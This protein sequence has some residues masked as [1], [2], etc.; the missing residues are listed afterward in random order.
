MWKRVLFV[1]FILFCIELGLFLILLP[2]TE[3][4]ERNVLLAYL[5][6]LRPWLLNDYVRGA[7]SG[8]GLVNL[9]VALSDI[10]NFRRNLAILE[11]QE[12]KEGQPTEPAAAGSDATPARQKPPDGDERASN[13]LLH[14]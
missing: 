6:G 2:W 8:L 3:I 10:W 9:W 13:P 4:W 11:Q 1:V 12:N 7:F 14:H 5:P